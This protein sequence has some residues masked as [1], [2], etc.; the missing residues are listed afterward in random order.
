MYQVVSSKSSDVPLQTP[1]R[2]PLTRQLVLTQTLSVS[3]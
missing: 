1:R 3:V 2:S